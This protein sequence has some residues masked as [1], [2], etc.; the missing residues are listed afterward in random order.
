MW[1]VMAWIHVEGI[2][3]A[4]GRTGAGI[5]RC[6]DLKPLL[7]RRKRRLS[8]GGT[9]CQTALTYGQA[10]LWGKSRASDPTRFL[11]GTLRVNG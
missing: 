7:V 4:N 5:G 8:T 3:E 1:A 10:D 2:E 6:G 11:D 9:L